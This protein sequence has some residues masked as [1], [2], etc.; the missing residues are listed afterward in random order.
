[1]TEEIDVCPDIKMPPLEGGIV[2]KTP[3]ES[4]I[5]KMAGIITFNGLGP[6]K[7]ILYISKENKENKLMYKMSAIRTP[8]RNIHPNGKTTGVY[9]MSTRKDNIS[10]NIF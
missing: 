6:K 2:R 7:F 9:T 4:K 8:I 10:I 5:N 3:G 1:M